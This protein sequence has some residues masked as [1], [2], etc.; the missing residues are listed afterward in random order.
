[1]Y[2]VSK[3]HDKACFAHVNVNC[4]KGL[5]SRF[6][7]SLS[8]KNKQVPCL[9]CMETISWVNYESSSMFARLF[10][11]K[12]TYD[13]NQWRLYKFSEHGAQLCILR[14]NEVAFGAKN[15]DLEG[16]DWLPLYPQ[17]LFA[18]LMDMCLLLSLVS[19]VGILSFASKYSIVSIVFPSDPF[20]CFSHPVHPLPLLSVWVSCRNSIKTW[21]VGGTKY[22]HTISTRFYLYANIRRINSSAQ[23]SN[24][25]PKLR[26]YTW[27]FVHQRCWW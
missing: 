26:E 5:S 14:R 16:R 19:A 6:E 11:I 7:V 20:S 23:T 10:L 15:S 27:V 4:K 12:Q 24:G 18:C 17:N 13:Q 25:H 1:M 22:T 2:T 9:I 3:R 8:C 21:D